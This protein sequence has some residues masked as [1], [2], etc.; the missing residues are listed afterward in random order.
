MGSKGKGMMML[1]V[2]KICG[3]YAQHEPT[4]P[5]SLLLSHCKR[6]VNKDFLG[7]ICDMAQNGL[8]QIETLRCPVKEEN[9]D[10]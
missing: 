3:Y 1:T 9:S 10:S 4:S 2:D 8:E 5:L 7:D 6:L